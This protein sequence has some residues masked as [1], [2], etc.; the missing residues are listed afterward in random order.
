MRSERERLVDIAQTIALAQQF[1]A[2]RTRE[3]FAADIQRQFAVTRCLEII[4][5]ASRHLGPAFKHRHPDIRWKEIA[6]AGNIY[7]HDYERVSADIIWKTVKDALPP[8]LA[9]V[10]SALGDPG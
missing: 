2:D 5:E 8:L 7:R 1:L 6:G 4:S 9:V 10:Q 3:Q